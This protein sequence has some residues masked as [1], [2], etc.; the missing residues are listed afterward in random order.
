MKILGK[1]PIDPNL[2]IMQGRQPSVGLWPSD[3]FGLF[4]TIRTSTSLNVSV[5]SNQNQSSSPSSSSLSSSTSPALNNQPQDET[6]SIKNR[7]PN[8]FISA[9]TLPQLKHVDGIVVTQRDGSRILE[10]I[11][12]QNGNIQQESLSSVGVNCTS[13]GKDMGF[14]LLVFINKS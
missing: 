12:R 9:T 7:P 11:D 2:V 1:E 5:D 6:K 14:Q 13:C 4:A 3:H 10:K 8:P